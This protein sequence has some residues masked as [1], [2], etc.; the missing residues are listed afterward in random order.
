[1]SVL[2]TALCLTSQDYEMLLLPINVISCVSAF[3]SDVLDY[4][5]ML[6]CLTFDFTFSCFVNMI[7]N[8]INVF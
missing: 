6:P 3:M 5:I 8:C 7:N 1:M 4:G 2:S